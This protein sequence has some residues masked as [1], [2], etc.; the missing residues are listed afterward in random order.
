MG[1]IASKQQQ[2]KAPAAPR[3]SDTI[4]STI[5]IGAGCYWGTEKYIRKDF[6]K[7][8]PNSI[9]SATVGFMSPDPQPRF[10]KPT[11]QQVCSGITGH[12]EVLKVELN[13]PAAHLEEMLRFFFMFHDPTTRNRQG[14][15]RG[16]QYASWIFCADDKQTEIARRVR[17]ELQRF[18]DAGVIRTYEGRTVTTAVTE[19]R[20]FTPAS[21]AH[22]RYLEKHPRGY[23]NHRFRFRDWPMLVK[24]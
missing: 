9:K 4:S 16:S 23:C 6:Q 14:N 2:R 21:E 5:V 13:D 15:D 11:Y 12:V 7:R 8:F 10:R 18:V 1:T 20:E 22:Q 3:A 17:D 24:N 19:L